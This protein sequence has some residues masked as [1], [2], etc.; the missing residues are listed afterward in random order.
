MLRK[1]QAVSNDTTFTVTVNGNAPAYCIIRITNDS[2][3]ISSLTVDNFTSDEV[4]SYTGSLVTSNTLVVDTD[5]H[6]VE[7][8]AVDGLADFT[9]DLGMMLMP[10]DNAMKIVGVVSGTIKVDWYDRWF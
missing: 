2:S 6:T 3:N 4:F 1:S 8:N 9:G 7:N 5:K 10:G